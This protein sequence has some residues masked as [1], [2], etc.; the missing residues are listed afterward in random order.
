[1]CRMNLAME[2]FNFNRANKSTISDR[3]EIEL[4]MG[5]GLKMNKEQIYMYIKVKNW[6]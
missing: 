5:M 4:L 6:E 1:M 3:V 2:I